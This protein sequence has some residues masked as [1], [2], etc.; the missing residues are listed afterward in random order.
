[1]SP[2]TNQPEEGLDKLLTRWY[3]RDF[4]CENLSSPRC[5]SI[6]EVSSVQGYTKQMPVDES[7]LSSFCSAS[8]R[9]RDI[10]PHAHRCKQAVTPSRYSLHIVC[11]VIELLLGKHNEGIGFRRLRTPKWPGRNSRSPIPSS[12]AGSVGWRS[13][14]A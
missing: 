5:S 12:E 7:I 10:C 9:F 14:R 13:R 6:E 8:V 2:G 11:N 3:E 1:M 4:A